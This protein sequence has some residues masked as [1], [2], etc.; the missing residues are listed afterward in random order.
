MTVISSFEA[1]VRSFSSHHAGVLLHLRQ[2]LRH[3]EHLHPHPELYQ[4]V[5]GRAE[6]AAQEPQTTSA[7]ASAE[8]GQGHLG[9]AQGRGPIQVQWRG[10]ICPK[11]VE[12]R[13]KNSLYID[14]NITYLI[15]CNFHF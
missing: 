2:R 7:P 14:G 3:Q 11:Q 9:G 8:P 12:Y 6:E 5:G 10:K 15:Q 1:L 13:F 4:E